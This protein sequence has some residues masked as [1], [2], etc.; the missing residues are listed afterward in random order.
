MRAAIA[1]I[2]LA[3]CAHSPPDRCAEEQEWLA[4]TVYPR[5]AR[6]I[7]RILDAGWASG[8]NEMDL[9]H[10]HV[11]VRSGTHARHRVAFLYHSKEWLNDTRERNIFIGPGM[12]M[13]LDDIV[14]SP[15]AGGIDMETGMPVDAVAPGRAAM[16][17]DGTILAQV[18]FGTTIEGLRATFAN[19]AI[20]WRSVAH[21]GG[22]WFG[23]YGRGARTASSGPSCAAP[24][25]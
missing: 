2:L 6:D 17:P 8:V 16:Q 3:A 18:N 21:V 20:D 22:Y 13:A 7:P 24:A 23:T 9:Y 25:P 11:Y 14:I 19:D 4:G 5:M 12:F 1:A 15:R 10:A